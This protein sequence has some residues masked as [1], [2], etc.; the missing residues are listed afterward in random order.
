MAYEWVK[1]LH[2]ISIIAWMAGLLYLP[3]LMVYHTKVPVGSEQSELFKVMERRLM[4]AIMTPA[5][6]ASW[7][8]GLWASVIT[9]AWDQPWFHAKLGLVVL[10]TISHF[11]MMSWVK[12]FKE[13]RNTRPEKFFRAVNEV[14][15]LLMIGIVILVI[16]RPF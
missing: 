13:D 16:V 1:A 12:A 10:L 11:F 9:Y 14:P 3:R 8:F 2:V 7:A 5:M 15:T 6:I 4:K